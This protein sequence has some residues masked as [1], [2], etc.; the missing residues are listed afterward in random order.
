M[1]ADTYPRLIAGLLQPQAYPRRAGATAA[2]V[3]HIETH[4]SHV[5]LSGDH[6]YKLKKV[7]DLGFLDYST[8]ERR[9]F[10]C[11][12]EVRLNRR[13]SPDLYRGV[14]AI[15]GSPEQPRMGGDGPVLEYAVDMGRF[16]QETLL[17]Q[18]T[19]TPDLIDRIAT[20]V[21]AFHEQI[22]RADPLGP[23]GTPSAVLAPMLENLQQV[24]ARVRDPGVADRLDRLR[25]WTLERWKVLT[26]A[27]GHRLETGRVRECHGDLHRANIALE[28]GEPLFFDGIE[29][30]PGLRWIDTASELAFL[31]MDLEEAE[32]PGLAGRLLNQYLEHTGDFGALE[33]LDLY[34]VYRAMV[35]AKVLAIRLD[36]ADLTA[37]QSATER[38]DCAHYLALAES[39][40]HTRRPCILI[41]CGLSGSG[42]STLARRLS[43]SLPIMIHLRSDV[44]RK[45]LFG[46][47][48][49][50]RS[51]AGRGA[52]IYF[53]QATAWTYLRLQC[54]AGGILACGYDVVVDA[55]FLTRARRATFQNL[56]RQCGAGFAIIVL[57][58]PLRLLRTRVAQRLAAGSDASE[59]SI[60]VLEHQRVVWERPSLAER[61]ST[62]I[63]NSTDLPPL[64]G[65]V[66]QI[67]ELTT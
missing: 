47:P 20:R 40:T 58:A 44:E 16:A 6:A 42:K 7:I 19:L 12:E 23:F 41:A 13:L 2:P 33:V 10:C 25:T 17:T 29:F 62:I 59:A 36:Q 51:D 37:A 67:A 15:T 11:E 1:D 56:A 21:A 24:R 3:D 22:P 49:E 27:I 14:V 39:Y 64:P 35:R 31:I 32:T 8:L 57:M 46:L 65:I 63:I 5:F 28:Q 60:A 43:E 66:R 30:N 45:R 26:P 48:G 50:T 9:H 18:V 61:R 52:G 4:I 38:C 34:K 55:T 54:L 53:P